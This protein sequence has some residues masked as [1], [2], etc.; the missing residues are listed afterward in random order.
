MLFSQR[1]MQ[2]RAARRHLAPIMMK[3]LLLASFAASVGA[4]SNLIYP[5]PRN[6]IDRHD[7]RW[8]GGEGTRAHAP[9]LENS[10]VFQYNCEHSRACM[11]THCA[12]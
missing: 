12:T 10:D 2:L 11:H 5:M 3:Y 1:S 9:L 7:P 4:H 6:A 8:M